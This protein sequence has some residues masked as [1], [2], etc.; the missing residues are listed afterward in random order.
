MCDCVCVCVYV[1]MFEWDNW[2]CLFSAIVWLI[3]AAHNIVVDCGW[4]D[5][6][7]HFECK[8]LLL[9]RKIAVH[10]GDFPLHFLPQHLMGS[11]GVRLDMTTECCCCV[12]MCKDSLILNRIILFCSVIFP[13]S[14]NPMHLE[15]AAAGVCVPVIEA[16]LQALGWNYAWP[17]VLYHFY[18]I[19]I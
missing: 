15:I 19:L 13:Q 6:G 10:I 4:P 7:R 14:V 8:H 2:T 17:S 5:F 9:F 18:K 1:C 16:C 12:D 11:G 3:A